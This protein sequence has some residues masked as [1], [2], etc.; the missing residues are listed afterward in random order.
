MHKILLSKSQYTKYRQC[1]KLFW[2]YRKDK[3]KIEPP[4]AQQQQI[5]D[6]GIKVGE[7]ACRLF[8]G[9]SQIPFD[10]QD[11]QGMAE[12]TNE[13]IQSGVETIYEASFIFDEIFVAIDILHHENG[14]WHIYEVKS[15]TSVKETYLDDA[16]IQDYVLEKSGIKSG[17]VNI[18]HINKT[19][20]R[21]GELNINALFSIVNITSEIAA[22][23]LQIPKQIKSMKKLLAHG[24]PHREIG[25]HCFS[26]YDCD[27]YNYC[28]RTLA[29]IPEK[30]VFSLTRAGIN[31]K[32]SLYRSG[33][34]K[35]SDVPLVNRTPAQQ[36]QILGKLD[37][38]P[39]PIREFVDSLEYPITHL[40]FETFLQAIPGYDGIKPFQQIPFQYSI[41]IEDGS[42]IIHK[43]YLAPIERDPRRNL[44]ERLIS[45][46]PKEGT[47][48][49]YNCSFEKGVIKNLGENFPDLQ[50]ELQNLSDRIEDL[51]T[52]FQKRWYYHPEMNG[53]YSI[54]KV[55]P[56]L[57]PEMEQAYADL[58][59]VHNGGEA[60]SIWGQ[61]PNVE[62]EQERNV[63]RQG[64][65]EYC[66][67]DTLAMVKILDVLRSV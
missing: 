54:K 43:E 49:A 30:S 67:L 3:S 51:M 24:E 33:I 5:F 50:E 42:S 12:K 1:P 37:I 27:A 56:A 10:I 38:S 32:F 14:F 48:L 35:I 55:L 17:S 44:A 7:I 46:I 2:L 39:A 9:G 65:L 26:P 8:P 62:D 18:I 45:D 19:Y 11:L 16:A 34:I 6:T 31:Q 59:G 22:R 47:I 36:L 29:D 53:S 61:L 13:L 20:V 63:I 21:N 25:P 15:S 60:S 28:W 66:R 58:P 4:A 57:V 40:D 64:L 23:K 52:P 41:H